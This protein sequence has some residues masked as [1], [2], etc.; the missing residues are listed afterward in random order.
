MKKRKRF[1]SAGGLKDLHS[2]HVVFG[3]ADL[4]TI[5]EEYKREWT[6]EEIHGEIAHVFQTIPSMNG[7]ENQ[8]RGEPMRTY[9][10]FDS[11]HRLTIFDDLIYVL[12]HEEKLREEDKEEDPEEQEL[13]AWTFNTTCSNLLTFFITFHDSQW[14]KFFRV[15][16]LIAEKEESLKIPLFKL[17]MWMTMLDYERFQ[18]PKVCQILSNLMH[19]LIADRLISSFFVLEQ[20]MEILHGLCVLA[21]YQA[22]V[23]WSLAF[24]PYFPEDTLA[25]QKKREKVLESRM[26]AEKRDYPCKTS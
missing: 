24:H 3:I 16:A 20:D 18:I 14:F 13:E 5:I 4:W 7:V 11:N 26:A 12:L 23:G 9:F 15:F 25:F 2:I 21:I 22:A 6:W 8:I 19:N 17:M 1:S 10:G